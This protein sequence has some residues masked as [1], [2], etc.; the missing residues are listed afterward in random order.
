MP[1]ADFPL[2]AHANS[3]DK[4]L[5][6]G[7]SGG[8][9][10]TVLL[11]LLATDDDARVRGLRA[12]HV[13][14]GLHPD[15]D[16]WAAHCERTCATLG[17]ALDVVRVEVRRDGGD[18]LEAAARSARHAAF[19]AALGDGETLV[20]AHHQDDQAE[21]FLL[22]ALRG[23]GVDGLAAMRPWRAFGRGWLWRPLLDTPRATLEAHAREHGLDWIED[24]SNAD[25]AHD[26]NF[27]RLRV[28]SLL[29][30]RWP[31]ADASFARS[32]ALQR[33]AA[34]LLDDGDAAA[35]AAV[36]C[37]D[38][39]C[40]DATKLAS[41]P[42]PRRARVL[43]RWITDNGLPPLPAEGIARI[44]RD[45]LAGDADTTP[46][47]AWRDAVVR[48]WRDL[49]WAERQRPALPRDYRVQWRGDTTLAL[50]TGDR[51]R[52]AGGA[53][54]ASRDES[55]TEP[56]IVHA[57][58][59]GERIA[60]PGRTHSHALKHVLQDLGVPPWLRMRMPLLSSPDGTLLAA[61]DLVFSAGFDAWLKRHSRSLHW[62]PAL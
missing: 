23:S 54:P 1:V 53:P 32:A 61:G 60:L 21:T 10:S 20:L 31:H 52:F 17:I 59:G 38:P 46:G 30:E 42:A 2:L 27:L 62:S 41:L 50:P 4:P 34:T 29:R 15:A 22:R 28:L 48:R 56:W 51:L 37:T 11:H 16:A 35:L 7:F 5:L 44:E 39:G 47:F 36:R 13:H 40:I 45:L 14:H 55:A 57:R 58:E 9:D 26:R 24:P 43:R 3:A 6:V 25:D 12:I 49:L 19:E 8:L 33:D 18:G